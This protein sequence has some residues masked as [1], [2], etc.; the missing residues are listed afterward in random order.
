PRKCD[1]GGRVRRN[2]SLND[3]LIPFAVPSHARQTIRGL[4]G[5]ASV[6]K[7]RYWLWCDADDAIAG[8]RRG[9]SCYRAMQPVCDRSKCVVVE[10]CH[11][12]GIDGAFFK[13]A[14]PA[15]PDRRRAHCDWIQPG[16]I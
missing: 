10:R 14:V 7:L 8:F 3:D 2:K 15:L 13:H 1:L 6:L 9:E 11:F 12:A 5:C 4:M 16:R